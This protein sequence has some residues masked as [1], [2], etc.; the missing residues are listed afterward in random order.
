MCGG[1][2]IQ[3]EFLSRIF[4]ALL[5]DLKFKKK[6]YFKGAT[7]ASTFSILIPPLSLI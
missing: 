1:N 5:Q 3:I 6:I 7:G 2:P 4:T